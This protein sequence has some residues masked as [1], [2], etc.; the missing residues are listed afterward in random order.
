MKILVTG[1][2]GFVGSNL[3]VSLKQLNQSFEIIAFDNLRR[4]GSELNISRLVEAGVQFLHGDVR[5][6]EDLY[7][8]S[9]IEIIIDASADPS[10]LSGINTDVYPLLNTNL[11]GSINILELAV[12]NKAKI[13]FLSTSR[14]YPVKALENLNFVEN[15]TRYLWSD[16]QNELG[17]SSY[18]VTE[19]FT[20]KGSRSFYG[21][22]KLASELLIEEYA[23]FKGISS[24]INRC[25][26][27]S[28]PWQMG[29]VDQGVLLL[30]L[31][32]H[33]F[34]GELS[35][36]GYG[37]LGKQ[38]RDVL[39]IDDLVQL[40]SFQINNFESFEGGLFNVG[41]SKDISFSL[42]ELTEICQRV[43]GNIIPISSNLQNREADL[44]IYMGD[45]QKITQVSGWKPNKS[46]EM[47]V[48]DSFDWL[49]SNE[50]IVKS[51]FQ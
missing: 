34:K 1:G 27:L 44:R 10:V 31:S 49:R 2:A 48:S 30:W 47:I 16:K 23:A 21:A 11:L 26:V 24:I 18:G 25:G 42:M 46:V 20:L 51:I 7:Q 41:G 45:N 13:I 33:Y 22:T 28:G 32:R 4:R 6:M 19:D 40:I 8:A 35:Y 12:K 43:T 17:I 38:T 3:C 50:K 36:I 14:V 37:G 39:H 5:N 15:E 29:K 9:D